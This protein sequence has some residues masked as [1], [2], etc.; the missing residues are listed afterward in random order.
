MVIGGGKLGTEG[1]GIQ[2]SLGS[3]DNLKSM[4]QVRELCSCVRLHSRRETLY[5]EM[6][7][8]R[9]QYQGTHSG[10]HVISSIKM[11]PVL[12]ATAS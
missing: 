12:M 10:L 2:F 4:I 3:C 9:G 11:S 8:H 5:H 7:F 6:K 1:G